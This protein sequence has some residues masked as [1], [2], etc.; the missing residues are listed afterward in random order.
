M[1]VIK[2][3]FFWILFIVVVIVIITY[4]A[5]KQ[6]D[7]CEENE[8]PDEFCY[9]GYRDCYEDCLEVMNTNKIK[10]D[11]SGFGSDECFCYVNKTSTQ[12]W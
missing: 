7:Y 6:R 9:A 10:Y 11:S 3:G 8:I 1:V 4:F 12:I 5:H 2:E